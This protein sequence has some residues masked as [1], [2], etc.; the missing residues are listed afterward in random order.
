MATKTIEAAR[1]DGFEVV[2][3]SIILRLDER[4]TSRRWCPDH[5]LHLHVPP[6]DLDDAVAVLRWCL[7]WRLDIC[8]LGTIA[9][10]TRV[11]AGRIMAFLEAPAGEAGDLLTFAEAARIM[12]FLDERVEDRDLRELCDEYRRV[13]EPYIEVEGLDY[14]K[15]LRR[16]R[17]V[18]REYR[19]ANP[20][21]AIISE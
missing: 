11:E 4:M 17:R 3:D 2:G 10:R 8:R 6:E 14:G 19:A 18:R 5:L 9:R 12:R 21:A 15:A 20:G 7:S 13:A 1:A 16:A